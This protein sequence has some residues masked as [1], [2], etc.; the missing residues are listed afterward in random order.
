MTAHTIVVAMAVFFGG[1]LLVLLSCYG[2]FAP[3]VSSL[4]GSRFDKESGP[5]A[6]AEDAAWNEFRETGKFPGVDEDLLGKPGWEN[7][8]MAGAD[9]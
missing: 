4:N 9:R 1:G 5:L 3:L 8:L 7:A 6:D 2:V